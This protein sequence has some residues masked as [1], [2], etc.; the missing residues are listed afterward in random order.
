[1]VED[2]PFNQR[3]AR[4]MLERLGCR[5]DVAGDGNAAIEMAAATTYDAILMDCQM[6]GLDGFAATQAIRASERDRERRTPIIAMT[7]LAMAGDQQRCLAA[8]MDGYVSK[9]MRG[10]ALRA[11][12][13]PW[14]APAVAGPHG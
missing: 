2:N 6:P 10:A 8:G 13:A 14:L 4:R 1:M 9:P 3:V 5:V 12:L 11:A 7:A